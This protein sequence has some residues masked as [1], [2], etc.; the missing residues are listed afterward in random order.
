M[1]EEREKAGMGTRTEGVQNRER[2][3]K[4]GNEKCQFEDIGC[5]LMLCPNMLAIV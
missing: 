1:G 4:A 3:M 2:G 5:P